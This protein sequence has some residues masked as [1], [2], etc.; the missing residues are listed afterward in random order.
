MSLQSLHQQRISI[1]FASYVL[2]MLLDLHGG[3][4]EDIE[5]SWG[6]G[7]SCGATA[8][9]RRVSIV[10]RTIEAH[11]RKDPLG[12]CTTPGDWTSLSCQRQQEKSERYGLTEHR[13]ECLLGFLE[14]PVK[15][16]GAKDAENYRTADGEQSTATA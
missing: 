3:K 12:G 15:S 7:A 14:F 16:V 11:L 1:R 6:R 4:D 2:G 10:L 8:K 13:A 5:S 9:G